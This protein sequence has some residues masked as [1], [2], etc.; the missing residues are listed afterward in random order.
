MEGIK[1]DRYGWRVY[2][3]VGGVQREARRDSDTP[4]EQL[5][6]LREDMIRALRIKHGHTK[7]TRDTLKADSKRYLEHMETTL[8]KATY[9][10]RVCEIEAWYP[11]LGHLPRPTIT[12]DH[13]LDVRKG[14]L[15]DGY[16]P[17]TCN[18]RTR[19]LAH[20]WRYL[21]GKKAPTPLDDIAKLAEPP[22]NPQFVTVA[23]IKRVVARIANPQT[24][25]RFMVLVSTGQRPAQLKRA[26][27]A[28]VNLKRGLW[29]V[30]PAKGGSRIPV[31][32]TDDMI[33]AWEVFIA[34]N[35][36]G[37][38]DSSDYAKQLYKAGWPEDVRPYNAKHTVAIALANADAEWEDIKD[39]FGHKDIKTTRIYTGH[40]LNRLK[41]TAER[42]SGRIGWAPAK[43]TASRTASRTA[44][45]RVPRRSK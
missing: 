44:S 10:S 21:D 33:A 14:W 11:A 4:I 26:Q 30:R 13:I 42:L 3:K 43:K 38:F 27:P 17:K 25:A 39:F 40:V 29:L 7:P 8:A 36:W 6:R 12:R 24:R 37:E 45:G 20:L 9:A 41:G 2:A 32:L 23:T 31:V 16:A 1:R 34:A 35:A 19:A 18:H 22:A 15:A 5:K 28:D